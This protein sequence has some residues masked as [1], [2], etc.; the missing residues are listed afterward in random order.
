MT[1]F[2]KEPKYVL[3]E[4][5]MLC[6]EEKNASSVLGLNFF[7]VVHI[8]YCI[9]EWLQLSCMNWKIEQQKMSVKFFYDLLEK[10]NCWL[11]ITFYS[12]LWPF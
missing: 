12:Y 5:F 6:P 9:I 1:P 11:I 7:L 8:Y 4:I 10:L 2:P 3:C